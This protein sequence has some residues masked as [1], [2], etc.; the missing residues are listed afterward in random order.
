[1]GK[2]RKPNRQGILRYVRGRGFTPISELRRYFELEP[3]EGTVLEDEEGKIYFGLPEDVAKTILTLAKDGKVG[4]EF[5]ADF[6]VRV[7]IGVYPIKQRKEMAE[8][9]IPESLGGRPEDRK[10]A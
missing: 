2:K 5:S 9:S 8:E 6:A 7:P 4:L 3:D 1:M 10:S